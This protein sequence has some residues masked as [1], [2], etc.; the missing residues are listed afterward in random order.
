M[1]QENRFAKHVSA[2]SHGDL[3]PVDSPQGDIQRH[4]T[5]TERSD[6]HISFVDRWIGHYPYSACFS[7]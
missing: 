7:G 4:M 3:N 6:P 5:P 2:L 1:R